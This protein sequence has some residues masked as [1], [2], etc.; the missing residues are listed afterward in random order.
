MLAVPAC[1]EK[2]EAV[3]ADRDSGPYVVAV[4][5]SP[6][7]N[8]NTSFLVDVTLA[9]LERRGARCEKIMLGKCHV[10]PCQGHEDCVQ[11]ATCARDDDMPAILDKAYAAQGLILAT[12]V[13]Y[14]DVS[15][16]MKIFIDRNYFKY[17]HESLL[18]PQA[19]GLIAIAAETGLE[20]TI[21][22]LKRFV[23]LSSAGS[24]PTFTLAGLAGSAGEAAGDHDLVAKA[25]RMALQMAAKLS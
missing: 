11:R 16:L 8:G 2:G 4:V 19:L 25:R 6:R 17:E 10:L 24:V 20:E 1:F 18:E 13:Y 23:A 12:P 3:S 7:A 21:E 14:E 15:A 5:G 9:E 22:T